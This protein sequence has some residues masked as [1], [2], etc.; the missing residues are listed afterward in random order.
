MLTKKCNSNDESINIY[1][2]LTDCSIDQLNKTKEIST[3][4]EHQL[5]PIDDELLQNTSFDDVLA[6]KNTKQKNAEAKVNLENQLREIIDGFSPPYRLDRNADGGGIM[7]YVREDI[8]SKLLS[9]ND[10]DSEIENIFVEINLRSK[11]WLICGTYNPKTSYIKNHLQLLSQSL[12]QYFLKYDNIIALGDFNAEMSNT[13]LQEF[14]AIFSLKNLIKKSTCFKSLEKPTGIDHFLT[15][16]PKSFQH[17]GT[18]ETG[19]SDF[20]KLTYTVLKMHYSKQQHKVIKYR[21]YKKFDPDVFRSDLLKEVSSIN[22]KNDEFDKFKYLVFKV[23]E[24]HAPVKEK[25]IRYNQGSF[26]TN[27]LRKAIMNRSRLLNKFKKDNSE[28][29]KWGYKKQRNL[30][31]KLLKKAK[32]TFYN[33]LDVKKISD[34]KTFWKTIKPN[35]TEKT[36]KDQKIT[37]VENDSV[38]SEDSELAE[39]FSKYF[40]N[41]VKNLNIQRPFFSQE[42]DD[43]IANAITNFEQY[44]S[45]LKIKENRNVCSPFSF[46]PVSLDEIIKETLNL[47]AS[48]ATQK[49]DIPTKIIKQNQD[50]F[51]EFIFENVN[52]MID[53]DIYPEQLKWAVVKPA[54]KKDFR[55]DKENFRPVSILPNISKIYERCLFK[56][57]TNYFEDLF[58]KYQCGFRKGFSVANCLCR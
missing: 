55:T 36:I 33:T 27:D 30:C 44:P 12:N 17:S 45:I 16:H 22:L 6:S 50:I 51:S 11:K 13:H 28:Q 49:S 7:L 29:N 32:R 15:N 42:H 40:E 21:C 24:A 26:M 23:L 10:I 34:N 43:P 14:C 46:E 56:Q 1:N 52:N 53:T 54:H 41:V 19:L 18:Y 57:L 37:L 3:Q 2:E 39:V 25:Y 4:T 38:I 31:V 48:K 35:F 47:D 58:S 5:N 8:P 20:H 9:N